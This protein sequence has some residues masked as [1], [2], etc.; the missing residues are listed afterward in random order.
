[1]LNA[2]MAGHLQD[3]VSR[4]LVHPVEEHEMGAGLDVLEALMPSRIELDHA[5]GFGFSGVL[6]AVLAL[7]PRGVDAPA[8]LEA[9]VRLGRQVDRLFAVA[10][11]EVLAGHSSSFGGVRRAALINQAAKAHSN[12]LSN[13][14]A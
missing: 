11:P 6:R 3:Q 12:G 4:R 1:M 2:I 14:L 5:N 9:S 7:L 8:E 13:G 10:D